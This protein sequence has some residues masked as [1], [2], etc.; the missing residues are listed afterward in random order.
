MQADTYGVLRP[1]YGKTGCDMSYCR[2]I[3]RRLSGN[4]HDAGN[5]RTYSLDTCRWNMPGRHGVFG[6]GS[7]RYTLTAAVHWIC[8]TT[9][10]R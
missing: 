9:A 7:G 1:W 4:P 5:D 8:G 3:G 6:A 2:T 10:T